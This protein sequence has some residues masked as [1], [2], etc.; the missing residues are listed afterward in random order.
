VQQNAERLKMSLSVSNLNQFSSIASSNDLVSTGELE[1]I[2]K[3]LLS[4]AP[5]IQSSNKASTDLNL[6]KINFNKLE[7]TNNGLKLFGADA[8]LS[9]ENLQKVA[10][11]KA[12]YNVNL[13]ENAMNSINLLNAQAA[14]LQTSA[15]SRQMDG[16]VNVPSQ[17]YDFSDSKSVFAA[18]N[19]PTTLE[20]GNMNKDKR[21]SNPFSVS[22]KNDQKQENTDNINIFA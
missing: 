11:N 19:A 3:E 22:L 14:K 17:T 20:I 15:Y 4:K 21:G 16:K 9:A 1:N 5:S 18:S 8:Q 2:S 6:S 10:A 12:G 7:S 13:S